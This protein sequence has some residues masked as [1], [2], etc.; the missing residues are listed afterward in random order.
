MRINR[1]WEI[2]LRKNYLPRWVIFLIDCVLI[3]LG[4]LS[5]MLLWRAIDFESLV[6]SRE[7]PVILCFIFLYI[8]FSL[9]FKTY[10]GI[11]RYSG[12]KDTFRLLLMTVSASVVFY[13]LNYYFKILDRSPS[14]SFIVISFWTIYI[15]SILYFFRRIVRFLYFA[16][17]EPIYGK[18]RVI[19]LGDEL[20]S[21]KLIQSINAEPYGSFSP[22]AILNI[23]ANRKVRQ[24]GEIPVV[25]LGNKGVAEVFKEYSADTLIFFKNQMKIVKNKIADECLNN[26][27]QLLMVSL[28]EPY[29]SAGKSISNQAH[30]ISIEDLLGRDV[31]ALDDSAIRQKIQDTIVLVT[32]AGGSIGSEIARQVASYSCKKIILFDTAETPLHSIWLETKE[33]Y[34]SIEVVPII[35]DIRNKQDIE[36][37][38]MKYAP[39]HVYHAA[40]YKHVPM[41]E[42]YPSEAVSV[43]IAGTKNVVDASFRHAAKSFVMISTDKAVNPTNVMGASKRIAEI[44]VQALFYEEKTKA[45]AEGNTSYTRV[46]TTRFG[47][48]LGSNGSVVPLFKKQIAKGGPVTITH[49]DIIRYFMTIPEACNLVLEASCMGKGGEVFIFDMGEPVRIYDL[50]R[51]M[52]QLA[53]LVPDRDIQITETGLRDGEK[54][55]EELLT[56][57]ETSIPTYNEKILIAKVPK[58]QYEIISEL[59]DDL[60]ESVRRNSDD[61]EIVR[62]M[63]NLAPE[64]KSQNSKYGILDK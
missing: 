53:G 31:I 23:R 27:I 1:K 8:L 15:F 34:P 61:I 30:N 18:K 16:W 25:N 21:L 58:V 50:A 19:V 37:V 3:F 41:M 17:F 44:Y 57:K 29:S 6:S 49:K 62:K 40:A 47:N 4:Y 13:I 60:I 43:N 59:V 63:K 51:K 36:N 48:V 24:I 42:M 39:E 54:L 56:N 28:F 52:I 32:G 26:G 64:Y 20:S 38:F 46:I 22:V 55:Y 9:I 2:F 35:G 5:F 33:L 14:T 7:I 45:K 12:S 10:G 11:I